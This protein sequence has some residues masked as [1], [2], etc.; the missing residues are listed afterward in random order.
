V[1]RQGA[2]EIAEDQAASVLGTVTTTLV[3]WPGRTG[4]AT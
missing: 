3:T 4:S 2:L 1:R